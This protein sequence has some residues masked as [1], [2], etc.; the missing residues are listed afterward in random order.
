L[1]DTHGIAKYARTYIQRYTHTRTHKNKTK[2][3]K[4][5]KKR[6]CSDHQQITVTHFGENK[7]LHLESSKQN[8]YYII[9]LRVIIKA[10]F[11][12][13]FQAGVFLVF[14]L[15]FYYFLKQI[16]LRVRIKERGQWFRIGVKFPT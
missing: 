9:S 6:R 14:V 3:K 13:S 8:Y 7:R 11:I 10:I 2:N 5:E 1:T 15:G 16:A 4:G 12:H